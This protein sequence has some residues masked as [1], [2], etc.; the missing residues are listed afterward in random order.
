MARTRL[1]LRT[2]LVLAAATLAG[3]AWATYQ[4][5]LVSYPYGEEEFRALVWV[6]FATPAAL[7]IGW[8]LARPRERLWAAFVCF[9]L[10][11]FS[12]FVAQRY[13]S[14]VVVSGGFSLGDCFLATER[15]QELAN[16]SGHQIYFDSVAT[17]Q[18]LIAL[19]IAAQRALTPAAPPSPAPDQPAAQPIA[20]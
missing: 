5:G 19:A 4:R 7:F 3:A 15:A 16:A 8:A 14:C 6:I 9:C 1:D 17:I 12:P 11:F 10:Y 2:L 20:G 18:A 13:E